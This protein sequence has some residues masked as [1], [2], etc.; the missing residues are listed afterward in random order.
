M[1]RISHDIDYATQDFIF[2]A[3][4]LKLS[5]ALKDYTQQYYEIKDRKQLLKHSIELQIIRRNSTK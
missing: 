4:K 5:I 3:L 1:I 2:V